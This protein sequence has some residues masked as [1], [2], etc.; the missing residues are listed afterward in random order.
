[1]KTAD[2]LRAAS[3]IPKGELQ[4]WRDCTPDP[5]TQFPDRYLALPKE[6]GECRKAAV[7]SITGRVLAL[8]S[9]WYEHL[10]IGSLMPDD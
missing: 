2:D 7:K 3:F 1:M 9:E 8:Y 4:F 5:A 10:G 6:Y